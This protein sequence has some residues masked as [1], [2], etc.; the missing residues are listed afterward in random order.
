MWLWQKETYRG[1]VFI[2]WKLWGDQALGSRRKRLV[3]RDVKECILVDWPWTLQVGLFFNTWIRQGIPAWVSHLSHAWTKLL[4]PSNG[5]FLPQGRSF[6]VIPA[7]ALSNLHK[8]LNTWWERRVFSRDWFDSAVAPAFTQDVGN[9][10][11]CP[12]LHENLIIYGKWSNCSRKKRE[13]VMAL[14]LGR[15]QRMLE[16]TGQHLIPRSPTS[17]GDCPATAGWL[18]L[19]FRVNLQS[20]LFCS[21]ANGL[22]PLCGTN[23]SSSGISQHFRPP[24][25]SVNTLLSLTRWKYLKHKIKGPCLPCDLSR[26][27]SE[28]SA[29][30]SAWIPGLDDLDSWALL[31]LR[32]NNNKKINGFYIW[33]GQS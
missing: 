28:Y 14:G 20:H 3:K 17:L 19:Y 32:K 1:N 24:I 27:Q 4:S 18:T 22:K 7:R 9:W 8:Y 26:K 6:T 11:S 5:Y 31:W 30:F 21:T 23:Y 16:K 15:L 12:C 33:F 29:V 13:T 25:F 2:Q 10:G